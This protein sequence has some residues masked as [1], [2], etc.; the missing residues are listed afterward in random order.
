MT[1]HTTSKRVPRIGDIYSMQFEGV[2][3]EQ[4]GWRPGVIFQNN[5]GNLHSP[6]LIVLP[7]T[8]NL[9]KM[10]MPTHVLLFASETGLHRDSLVICENPQRLSKE[11]LGKY[12]SS[13]SDH[14][15]RDIAEAHLIATS[16][17][18]F[19]DHSTLLRAWHTSIKLNSI[20]Y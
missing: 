4:T 8:S 17:I 13:L 15:M 7:I 14:Y 6:N 19:L 9:K 20:H 1:S 2:G 11:R 12:I 10:H 18:S 16:A 3:S 5:T